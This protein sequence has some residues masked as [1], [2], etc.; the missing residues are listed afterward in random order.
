MP[1]CGDSGDQTDILAAAVRCRAC[2]GER[3]LQSGAGHA[4]VHLLPALPWD[5][6]CSS[7]TQH[8][9]IILC[10]P[11]V[12]AVWCGLWRSTLGSCLASAA[13]VPSR[14]ENVGNISCCVLKC[15]WVLL[16]CSAEEL[17][18]V[19]QEISEG[20]PSQPGR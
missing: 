19:G 20:S 15:L 17:A 4:Q 2:S 3:L 5:P 1:G 7:R 10:V 8:L 9:N 6:V 18:A 13:A 11:D 12:E 14:R 16:D